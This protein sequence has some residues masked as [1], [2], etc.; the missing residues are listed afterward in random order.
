MSLTQIGRYH[1]AGSVF[2]IAF[3]EQARIDENVAL[4]LLYAARRHL[5]GNFTDH[6]KRV[7]RNSARVRSAF[8]RMIFVLERETLI[9]PDA[10]RKV[11][12]P[13]RNQNQ[14]ALERAVRSDRAGA[15]KARVKSIVR[16]EEFQRRAFSKKLRGRRGSEEFVSAE[17]EH[18]LVII[19][20]VDFDAEGRVLVLGTAL[21]FADLGCKGRIVLRL[22]C[23][24]TDESPRTNEE[25]NRSDRQNPRAGPESHEFAITPR[26]SGTRIAAPFPLA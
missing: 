17:G 8:V 23:T 16:T 3:S 5:C 9:R 13:A 11:R 18:H 1:G 20:R 22:R 2:V 6:E 19:Q 10:A 21:N 4:N 14:V 7:A 12:I 26:T 24:R 25:R 15:I